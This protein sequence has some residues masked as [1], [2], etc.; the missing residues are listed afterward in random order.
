MKKAHINPESCM[1]CGYCI[2]FCRNDAISGCQELYAIV[3]PE[4]CVGCGQCIRSCPFNC[5]TLQE[6]K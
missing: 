2:L 5:I 3:D 1:T 4:K 6:V